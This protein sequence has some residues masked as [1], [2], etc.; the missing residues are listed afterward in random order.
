MGL[1]AVRLRLFIIFHMLI[2]LSLVRIW[3]IGPHSRAWEARIITII[4]YPLVLTLYQLNRKFVVLTLPNP[5]RRTLARN[6]SVC[7][8]YA[9]VPCLYCAEPSLA[10]KLRASSHFMLTLVPSSS[11]Q[12]T[13]FSS[14][15]P[16]FNSRWDH[17]INQQNANEN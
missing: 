11:G 4:R 12:D 15:Q 10:L 2:V 3:G 13:R 1:L 9:M 8:N 17:H 5:S 14:W 6:T 7:Y 16:G